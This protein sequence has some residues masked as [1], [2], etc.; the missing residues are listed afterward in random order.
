MDAAGPR[1]CQETVDESFIHANSSEIT[2][3]EPVDRFPN[4]NPQWVQLWRE[5]IIFDETDGPGGQASGRGIVGT[6]GAP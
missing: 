1:G 3:L 4:P 2:A 6:P 5:N